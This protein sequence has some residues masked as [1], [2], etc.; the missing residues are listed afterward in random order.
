MIR[1]LFVTILGILGCKRLDISILNFLK[2]LSGGLLA[3]CTASVFLSGSTYA[4]TFVV[5]NTTQLQTAFE[6]AA[7][8]GEDDIIVME[9]GTYPAN[10]GTFY[11][12]DDES[13]NLTLKARDG[14]TANDVIIDGGVGDVLNLTSKGDFNF[15]LE[16]VSIQKGSK[17]GI[18]FKSS[19]NLTVIDS[20]IQ[21]NGTCG[22]S[23]SGTE[24]RITVINS[25]ISNNNRVGISYF[26]EIV[27]KGSTI[28]GNH[29]EGSRVN[30]CTGGGIKGMNTVIVDS[31][32]I[33]DNSAVCYAG[34]GGGIYGGTVTVT[35]SILFGN[36]VGSNATPHNYNPKPAGGAIRGGTVNVVN[37]TIT[38]NVYAVSCDSCTI[39]NNIFDKNSGYDV[40]VDTVGQIFNN[41]IDYTNLLGGNKLI[42]SL[43]HI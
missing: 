42:L 30:G 15:I 37:S 20:I 26:K 31:S 27:V 3:I 41:Y 8:N 11:F 16:R 19:Q 17:C 24:A 2:G 7:R 28:S 34:Y 29:Y 13:H 18:V 14:L 32:I 39:V 33:S 23:G 22:I 43:I 12:N 4:A 1:N 6:N 25:T 40:S 35:N 10:Q 38:G 5:A 21:G 9:R 36:D